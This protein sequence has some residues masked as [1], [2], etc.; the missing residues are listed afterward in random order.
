MRINTGVL[1]IAASFVALPTLAHELNVNVNNIQS[2]KGDLLVAVYDKKE[3]YDADKN[4]VAVKK[5]KVEKS[6]LSLDFADLPAGHYAVKLF[7]DENQNGQIDMNA[8]GVPVE[9]YG[10]SNNQGRSGQPSF[11]E[12]KVV[13]DS[14][15]NIEIQLR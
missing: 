11:E 7:Q 3:N 2:I 13:L 9:P 15:V 10:F 1:A 8:L 14:S 12:A 6:S 4:W 5:I